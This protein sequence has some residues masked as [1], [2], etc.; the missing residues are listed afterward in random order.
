VWWYGWFV[1]D[2]AGWIG[3]CRTGLRAGFITGRW[4]VYRA[5][6]IDCCSE[7]AHVGYL[8]KACEVLCFVDYAIEYSRTEGL[9]DCCR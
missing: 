3:W 2:G 5:M 7:V 9:T 8:D 6:A 1:G 4:G